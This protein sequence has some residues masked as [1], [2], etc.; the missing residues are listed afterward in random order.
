MCF[1]HPIC[2]SL[3]VIRDEINSFDTSLRLPQY[4]PVA[5]SKS[6]ESQGAPRELLTCASIHCYSSNLV[7]KNT[8]IPTYVNGSAGFVIIQ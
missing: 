6:G 7:G 3:T 8:V 1:V 4:L 2:Q 5:V